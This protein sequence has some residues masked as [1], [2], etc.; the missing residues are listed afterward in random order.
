MSV[1]M[2][3]HT[4]ASLEKETFD[5][6]FG[7]VAVESDDAPDTFKAA[8]TCPLLTTPTSTYA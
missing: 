6:E 3:S 8:E 1:A 5:A 2:T 7:D 4:E